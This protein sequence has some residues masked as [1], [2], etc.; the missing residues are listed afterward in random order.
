MPRGNVSFQPSTDDRPATKD[1]KS[2]WGE[3][4]AVA[5]VIAAVIGATGAI[6][7]ALIGSGVINVSAGP[8]IQP[9]S[10]TA[11]PPSSSGPPPPAT[12]TTPAPDPTPTV[13]VRRST[14]DKPPLTLTSDYDADLDSLEPAWG[15][16]R[17][18]EDG[19]DIEFY[20]SGAGQLI[21]ND[22]V[23]VDLA[24]VSGPPS[25]ETCQTATNYKTELTA[26]EAKKGVEVCVR[27]SEKRFAFVQ[28]KKI[29]GDREG[30][31][32]DV[33]VWD[34]PFEE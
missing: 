12:T 6:V 24:E 27:T 1:K 13:T 26:N 19:Y 15:V 20:S 11:S 7:V 3:P 31:Q 5:A 14:K 4:Q 16:N 2:F 8:A 29:L 18:R 34:P 32:M 28:I 17:D 23:G 21:T 30:I 10:A 9:P 25:F 33:T 22:F